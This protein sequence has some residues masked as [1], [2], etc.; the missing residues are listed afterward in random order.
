MT[1]RIQGWI[2]RLIEYFPNQKERPIELFRPSSGFIGQINPILMRD[3]KK[4]GMT[5]TIQ[6]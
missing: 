1:K 2:D 6:V 3:I 4:G 5:K